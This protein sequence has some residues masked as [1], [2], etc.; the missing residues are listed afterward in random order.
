MSETTETSATPRRGWTPNPR[1]IRGP[2]PGHRYRLEVRAGFDATGGQTV[3]AAVLEE[4]AGDAV[5]IQRWFGR[6]EMAVPWDAVYGQVR[7]LAGMYRGARVV[8]YVRGIGSPIADALEVLGLTVE[9]AAA[10]PLRPT[11]REAKAA[12]APG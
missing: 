5:A 11:Q 8:V 10:D 1:R 9:R 2:Q 4:P 3:E 6:E 7:F 12:A